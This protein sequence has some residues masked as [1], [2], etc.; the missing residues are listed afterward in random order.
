MHLLKSRIDNLVINMCVH[1]NYDNGDGYCHQQHGIDIDDLK[2][3]VNCIANTMTFAYRP[4][5]GQN[6]RY[7]MTSKYNMTHH[8]S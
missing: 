5:M 2:K 4:T 8:D 6:V 3:C 7:I 1:E